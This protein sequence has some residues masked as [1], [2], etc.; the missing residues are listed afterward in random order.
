MGAYT[1][2]LLVLLTLGLYL[3]V[4][5]SC[6]PEPARQDLKDVIEKQQV[7]ERYIIRSSRSSFV[8][9]NVALPQ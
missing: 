1:P 9:V 2:I 8:Q 4:F 6:V 7:N 5:G 3:K